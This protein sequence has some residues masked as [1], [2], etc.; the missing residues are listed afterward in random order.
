[1]ASTSNIS[2]TSTNKSIHLPYPV[3]A[4]AHHGDLLQLQTFLFL[5]P[6]LVSSLSEPTKTTPLHHAAYYGSLECCQL[7]VDAGASLN[8][9]DASGRT[10]LHHATA[11]GAL[12]CIGFLLDRGADVNAADKDLVTALH[13]AAGLG[14]TGAVNK[15]LKC[16]ADVNLQDNLGRTPVHV[17]CLFG[18]PIT[19]TNIL[20]ALIERSADIYKVDHSGASPLHV[21][22][23]IG[24]DFIL[25]YL[26]GNRKRA[27][28][29]PG[30]VDPSA[31]RDSHGLLLL[32]CAALSG[33]AEC[34][35]YWLEEGESPSADVNAV[36]LLGQSALHYAAFKG[37]LASI[38]LLLKRGAN[39][40]L[41][42][43]PEKSTPL[44][45]ACASGSIPCIEALLEAGALLDARDAEGATP[46]HKAAFSGHT[47][48][49]R[50]L[51]RNKNVDISAADAASLSCLHM[52]ASRGH[53]GLL[54]ILLLS[55]ANFD[56]NAQDHLGR[57]PLHYACAFGDASTVKICLDRGCDQR[58]PD[59]AGN[60]PVHLATSQGLAD[61][62]DTLVA[63][64]HF[65]PNTPDSAGRTPL[66]LA[67][68]SGS[69]ESVKTLLQCPELAIPEGLDHLF[70]N[71]DLLNMSEDLPAAVMHRLK[72]M[73]LL[74]EKLADALILDDS[75]DLG[76]VPDLESFEVDPAKQES[77]EE[78][79]ALFNS[80]PHKGILFL[81]T[82]NVIQRNPK[83]VARFLFIL[84]DRL[85][86]EMIGEYLGSDT[87]FERSVRRYFAHFVSFKGLAFDLA[88]R[89]FLQ[90]FRLPLE[91]QK[92]DRLLQTFAERYYFANL[93][94]P[95]IRGLCGS[96]LQT[97]KLAF[98]T[99]MLNTDAHNDNVKKEKKMNL[100]QFLDNILPNLELS[101]DNTAAVE[102]LTD[103]YWRIVQ[104]A[105]VL[106]KDNAF[107]NAERAGWLHIKL[108]RAWK[109]RWFVLNDMTLF[110]LKTNTSSSPVE[111]TFDLRVFTPKI[112]PAPRKKG[113]KWYIFLL[114]SSAHT[115]SIKTESQRE[116]DAWVNAITAQLSKELKSSA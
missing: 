76:P 112:D 57:T 29:S 48:L 87:K 89:R 55:G 74:Q 3:H 68:H 97:H 34:L 18:N 17:A 116:V 101:E 71:F 43:E 40:N 96:P 92:I 56:M 38:L 15:L 28:G 61:V 47:Q 20:G 45:K 25:S 30:D 5:R 66:A 93:E 8:S 53:S 75:D 16:Q 65:D 21:A 46:L 14:N 36:D 64:P 37:N 19:A 35:K 83:V 7:L 54:N 78:G 12:G 100:T 114:E 51:Q 1:M 80:R 106:D 10:P 94:S 90:K 49:V 85:N 109:R 4:A 79:I 95:E 27:P 62:L 22:A 111:G 73:P 67:L 91:A 23:R 60:L 42:S 115:V 32:H 82:N 108:G 77:F 98:A 105:I 52:A 99:L 9:C 104:N 11:R 26:M 110:Y 31:L 44:H 50:L 69:A 13:L 103:L 59:A 33:N 58:L 102:Q 88:L 113:S 39:P 6:E 63:A 107:S 86:M 72:N 81:F 84:T 41:A 2:D 24:N 70:A